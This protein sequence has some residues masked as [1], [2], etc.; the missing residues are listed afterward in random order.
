MIKQL[1]IN[2]NKTQTMN[3]MIANEIIAIDVIH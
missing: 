2:E 3:E 1:N